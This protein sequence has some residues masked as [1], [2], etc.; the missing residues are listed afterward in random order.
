MKIDSIELFR[1]PLEVADGLNDAGATLESVYVCLHSGEHRGFGE[2]ALAAAPV[3]SSEW[4][5]GAFAC[6]RDWF[7]PAIVGQSIESGE[8]LQ[9][10]LSSFHGNPAAKCAL[11]VAWW[12]LAAQVRGVTLHRLLHASRTSV[13]L[14]RTLGVTESIDKLLAAIGD[15][16]ASGYDHVTLKLRPGWDVEMLRAV[17]QT[18]PDEPIAVDCDALCTLAQQ[19]MFYRLEDFFLRYIEQPL[20]AD[21]LVGHAM[22]QESLRTPIVLDQSVTS[23]ERVEQALDLGSCRMMRI[24]LAQVGG[25]TPA[26]AIHKACQQAKTECAVGGGPQSAVAATAAAIVAGVCADAI[27]DDAFTWR[28][29]PW[30]LADDTTMIEQDASGKLRIDLSAESVALGS[31]LDQQI[32][33]DFALEQAMIG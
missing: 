17:R 29:R 1:V 6:L 4:A 24:D 23:L 10:A 18:F 26:L 8:A 25:I 30:L 16:L 32:A 19:E 14:S 27:A 22:L 33:R 9:Q 20:A 28:A 7:A 3:V 11:D 31:L 12:N 21:D 15:A 13:R 5:A 2:A